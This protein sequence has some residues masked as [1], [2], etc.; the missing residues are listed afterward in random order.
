M[1]EG[2]ELASEE[3][4]DEVQQVVG[5]YQSAK[6][7]YP[8]W[9]PLSEETKQRRASAGHPADEP[10]KVTEALKRSYN[11]RVEGLEGGVGSADPVALYQE[12]GSPAKNLPARPILGFA[13]VRSEKRA[14]AAFLV[15]L[16]ALLADRASHPTPAVSESTPLARNKIFSRALKLRTRASIVK[17]LLP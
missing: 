13:F 10:E 2:I 15:P 14:F 12:V 9:A 4:L 5:H 17:R 16:A 1:S 3:I 6:G 7:P 8:A 11:V